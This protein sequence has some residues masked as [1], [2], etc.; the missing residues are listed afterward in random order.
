MWPI[1]SASVEAFPVK[2]FYDGHHLPSLSLPPSF[3]TRRGDNSTFEWGFREELGEEALII[4]I[5][6]VK[7]VRCTTTKH[8]APFSVFRELP[9]WF[10]LWS[11]AIAMAIILIVIY[12]TITIRRIFIISRLCR[13]L[14]GWVGVGSLKREQL[15][16]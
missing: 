16:M 11:L 10:P 4:F 12:T 9:S 2:T 13:R 14:F 15:K 1:K 7:R 3:T 8:T 6:L 5:S